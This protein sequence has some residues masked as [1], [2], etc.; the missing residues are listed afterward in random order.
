MI[1]WWPLCAQQ[2]AF[3][4]LLRSLSLPHRPLLKGSQRRAA[5]K[6]TKGRR[7]PLS[8]GTANSA[9]GLQRWQTTAADSG[10]PNRAISTV[11]EL[12][13]ARRILAKGKGRKVA[14]ARKPACANSMMRPTLA[15]LKFLHRRLHVAAVLR[16]IVPQRRVDIIGY[17]FKSVT[18]QCK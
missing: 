9:F 15:G 18:V 4:T 6:R 14:V 2:Y 10:F 8:H 12:R 16:P 13:L 7:P 1:S 11:C 5:T 17:I 3:V